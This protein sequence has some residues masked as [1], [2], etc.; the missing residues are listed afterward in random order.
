MDPSTASSGTLDLLYLTFNCAK[1]LLN[2]VVFANHLSRAFSQ[3][4]TALP[5]V[6]VL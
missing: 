1:N 2:V 5:D 4:A 6:V 3:N